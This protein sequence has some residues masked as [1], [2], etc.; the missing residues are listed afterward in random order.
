MGLY[1]D[2]ILPHLIYVCCGRAD[3]TSI[4][5]EVVP[6]AAGRVLEIGMGAG[7][8]LAL[9]DPAKVD[10]VLGLEPSAGMRRKA[11]AALATSPVPVEL[12][13]AGA[14]DIP[15]PDASVDTVVLTYTLCSID[16]AEEALAEMR[17][18]LKPGGLM[19][20][21]EHGRDPDPDIYKWQRR[22]EPVWK[23]VFGGCRLTRDA[24]DM[25][26][27]AG[28]ALDWTDSRVLDGMPRFGARQAY[29]TATR[30]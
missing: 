19:L 3:V 30:P 8:N 27:S 24:P 13:A 16:D 20:F 21:A 7:A 17:R 28:F 5:R 15:L 12:I 9:Y 29:G 18:V 26:R 4:R 25:L 2:H 22:I 23:P 10:S 14:E 11:A 6:R 1:H